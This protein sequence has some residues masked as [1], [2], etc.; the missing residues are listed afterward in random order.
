MEAGA[1]G[2]F[3]DTRTGGNDMGKALIKLVTILALLA[4][5]YYAIE[6]GEALSRLF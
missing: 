5:L 3:S 6:G 4:L 1:V 2:G